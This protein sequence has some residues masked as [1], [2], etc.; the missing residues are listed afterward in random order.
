MFVEMQLFAQKNPN[1]PA[2]EILRMATMNGAR[3]LG[4]AQSVGELSR[5][6]HAD[7][8]ALPYDGKMADIYDGIVHHSGEVSASMIEG[9]WAKKSVTK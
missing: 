3:A 8:I 6:S 5:R 2:D 4:L 1:A 7:I 9:E